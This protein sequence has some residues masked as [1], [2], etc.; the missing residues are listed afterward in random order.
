MCG[1]DGD[2]GYHILLIPGVIEFYEIKVITQLETL[3][4]C[5]QQFHFFNLKMDKIA[6][7]P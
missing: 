3:S 5:F 6:P 1:F 2:Q 7:S 4:Y